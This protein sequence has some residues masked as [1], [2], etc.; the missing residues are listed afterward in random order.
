[1]LGIPGDFPIGT[2]RQSN[3]QPGEFTFIK[4]E[5]VKWVMQEACVLG[6]LNPGHYMCKHIHLIQSHSNPVTAAVA[7]DVQ[8]R[9][10][11]GNYRKV[12]LLERRIS[13]TLLTWMYY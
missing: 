9:C 1:M 11:H 13:E 12:P 2:V 7:S 10:P 3:Q 6:H 5:N 8:C 4:G